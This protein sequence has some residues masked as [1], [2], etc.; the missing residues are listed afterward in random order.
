MKYVHIA[1][2]N[3]KGSVSEYIS[4]ILA[5]AGYRC[6]CYTSPHLVSPTERMKINGEYI[7]E[8]ELDSLLEEVNEKHLAV[9]DS[10]FAAYTAA[11][12]LWFERR[13]A[14]FAVMETGLG[15]R[16]DPTNCIQPSVVVLTTVDYDHMDLLGDTLEKIAEEKCGIIKPGVP[17]VSAMQH[18][19]AV[20][21][22]FSH[23]RRKGS[24]LRFVKPVEL[25]SSTVDGQSFEYCG[26]DYYISAIGQAQPQN[27]ALALLAAKELGISNDAIK[28]GL[29]LTKL[30]CRIQYIKGSPDIILDGGHNAGAINELLSTLDTHFSG[31]S[32]VL[33]FACMKDKD[34]VTIINSLKG[35]FSDVVAT[36]VEQARGASPELLCDLYSEFAESIA[37]E[38]PEYAFN[39]AK[40][41]AITRNALL[42][43]CGSFYLAGF[44]SNQINK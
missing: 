41:I 21:V 33:L 8:T 35:V 30:K 42:V 19:E 10:Q 36:Q 13:N 17:V 6:G 7:G 2:T 23:C 1:G 11:A 20:S 14:D 31:K 24:P 32:K 4:N 3:G 18:E 28:A 12:I 27:A 44:V 25:I 5:A 43:I 38:D 9:N 15:G 39:R 40:H 34:Y 22:I 29:S 16:L 37:E 26:D